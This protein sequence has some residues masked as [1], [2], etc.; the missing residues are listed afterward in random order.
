MHSDILTKA[1]ARALAD[2]N[3]SGVVGAKVYN[4]VPK[5]TAPPY[6]RI[7]WGEAESIPDKSDLFTSGTL[8]FDF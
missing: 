8:T 1:V 2:A 6:L 3:I 4:N 7:Q 5:D